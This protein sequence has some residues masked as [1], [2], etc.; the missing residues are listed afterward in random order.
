[1]NVVS[2]RSA[3]CAANAFSVSNGALL[4]KNPFGFSM[5]NCQ[6]FNRRLLRVVEAPHAAQS[7]LKRPSP[8]QK[9]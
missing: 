2:A 7:E 6:T 3:R 4:F 9:R 8:E 5:S 1:M